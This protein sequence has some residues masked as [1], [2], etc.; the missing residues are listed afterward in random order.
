MEPWDQDAKV[1]VAVLGGDAGQKLHGPRRGAGP[2]GRH[3]LRATT[4]EV[5]AAE[6][7]LRVND[8]EG[9]VL[10]LPVMESVD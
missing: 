9:D 7:V 10:V 4:Q 5:I 3:G 8:H 1:S 6:H 2:Q